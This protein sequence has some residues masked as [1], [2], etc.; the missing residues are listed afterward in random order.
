MWH[1][2]VRLWRNYW[3]NRT[4]GQV[5]VQHFNLIDSVVL[6][7]NF[8]LK[9]I[10]RVFVINFGLSARKIATSWEWSVLFQHVQYLHTY[11]PYIGKCWPW[12]HTWGSPFHYFEWVIF[13][14][15]SASAKNLNFAKESK[16]F[17]CERVGPLVDTFRMENARNASGTPLVHK[18]SDL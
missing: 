8:R 16:M 6:A 7:T 15:T 9:Y 13:P 2:Q 10:F 5:K 11:V 12:V 4:N 18:H 3:V 14:Y 17:K 1:L